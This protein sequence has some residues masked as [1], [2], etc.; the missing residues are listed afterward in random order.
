MNYI[1]RLNVGVLLLGL[2][3]C[4]ACGDTTSDTYVP[5]DPLNYRLDYVIR[6]DSATGTVAVT[7]QLSQARFLLRKLRMRLNPAISDLE[8]DGD[9]SISGDNV[10]WTP[11]QAGGE[12][13]W[14]VAVSHRRNGDGYDAWLGSDWGLF[15]AEDII[16]RAATRTLKGARSE[17]WLELL[18]PGD[19]SA[20][21]Q[22]FD[23]DG[24][25][26]V[27]N[28]ARRFDQPTGWIVLGDLGVR[29]DTISGVR[30]A[31]AGPVGHK[32]RRM[33]TLALLNWTLPELARLLPDLPPRLT[34]VS[35][36]DPM[37]RGGL[38]APQSLFI[39]ADRPLI[40]ENATSTLLH[41]VL[42]MALGL[43][44]GDGYD[45][46][47]E[48]LAE[49]YSLELLQRSGTISQ[50]RYT[51]ARSDLTDWAKSATS[52]CKATSTGATTAL[53]VGIFAKLDR[54][55]REAT[56][57]AASMD[58]VTR[59]LT[60]LDG[61]IDLEQLLAIAN[62]ISGVKPDALHIDRLPGC[63]TLQAGSQKL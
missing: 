53:A 16:P 43:S 17:T 49:Y 11:P 10:V 9:I 15:R 12:I 41:E 56:K 22:Y 59:Q 62:E 23:D 57:G 4:S 61:R 46:I 19:W 5:A 8:G 52:L 50:Q 20:V 37:W 24:V 26:R 35:A 63:R 34:I 14:R 13:S 1:S 48:G 18:L 33:D 40:S 6:P 29:R 2:A 47:I 38:S 44:A 36:G 27:N 60:R 58:D 30:V 54:E 25:M 32:I 31:V 55:V 42:H 3:W 21:T 45:W 28:P 7:L 39:H 51:Q